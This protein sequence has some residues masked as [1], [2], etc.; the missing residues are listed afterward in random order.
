[1]KWE[2][3]NLHREGDEESEKKPGRRTGKVF[4]LTV[5]NC[6]LDADEIK[7]TRLGIKPQNRG[8]HEHRCDH[9]VQEEFHCGINAASVAINADQQSHRDQRGFPEKVKKK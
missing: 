3:W 9:G 7:R 6:G 4:D 2:D 1:M 5:V 8:E